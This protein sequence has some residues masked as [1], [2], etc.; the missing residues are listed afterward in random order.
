MCTQPCSCWLPT[1][2][3]SQH[4]QMLV[5][6]RHAPGVWVL[7]TSRLASIWACTCWLRQGTQQAAGG[8]IMM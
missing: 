8:P 1:R 3:N 6:S 2:L 5:T 7:I 4:G